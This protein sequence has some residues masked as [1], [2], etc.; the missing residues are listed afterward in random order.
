MQDAPEG[1]EVGR[2]GVVLDVPDGAVREVGGVW[3]EGGVSYDLV[4]SWGCGLGV[5]GGR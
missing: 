5:E 3:M 1:D 2:V 4:P